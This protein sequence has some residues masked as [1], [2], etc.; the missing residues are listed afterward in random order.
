MYT[1]SLKNNLKNDGML[2]S[3]SPDLLN[4][5]QIKIHV[6]VIFYVSR[7]A[8]ICLRDGIFCLFFS[9]GRRGQGKALFPVMSCYFT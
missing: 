7:R 1:L 9:G 8:L 6:R 5:R 2:Q 4:S 3:V